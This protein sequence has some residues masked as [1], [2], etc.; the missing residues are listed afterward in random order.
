MG[1]KDKDMAEESIQE[2]A[3]VEEPQGEETKQ[4]DWKAEARKWESRAKKSEQAAQELEALKM[5]QLSEQEKAEARAQ[6]AE[7]E[8]AEMK[9]ERDRI[10]SARE[11]SSEYGVPAELLEYCSN[12]EA[13]VR[14]VADYRAHQAPVH[15]ASAASQSRIVRDGAVSNRDKFA[16][17]VEGI[18]R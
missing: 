3:Q 15:A 10:A 1:R 7:A 2:A 17:A 13:M 14:F 16:A 6:K 5:A 9:A 8:L 18:I 4:T 11:L 12:R